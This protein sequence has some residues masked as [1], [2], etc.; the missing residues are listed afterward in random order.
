MAGLRNRL[1]PPGRCEAKPHAV[2]TAEGAARPLRLDLVRETKSLVSPARGASNRLRLV[3]GGIDRASVTASLEHC[4]GAMRTR[5]PSHRGGDFRDSESST[6]V[7]PCRPLVGRPGANAYPAATSERPGVA[8]NVSSASRT[9][10]AKPAASKP[11]DATEIR[12]GPVIHEPFARDAQDAHRARHDRPDRPS[13]PPR[14]APGCR[15]RSRRSRRS[16]RR[17]RPSACRG[18]GRGS[19]DGR[20]AAHNGR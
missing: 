5:Q 16:P 1:D 10:A 18:P 12:H 11:Q 6:R 2:P 17:S 15:S 13:G 20:V 7:G 14:P 4:T 8:R 19:A 9:W 3:R